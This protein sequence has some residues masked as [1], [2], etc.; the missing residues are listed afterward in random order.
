MI[1]YTYEYHIDKLPKYPY[2][3]NQTDN[4]HNDFIIGVSNL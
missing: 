1:K 3:C 4:Q 2:L